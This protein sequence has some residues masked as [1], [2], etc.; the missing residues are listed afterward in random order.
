[1]EIISLAKRIGTYETSI[2]PY[3]DC[4]TIFVPDHPVINPD[5]E[6]CEEYEK[7]IPY[8]EM[9]KEAVLNEEIV[10]NQIKKEFEDY[11]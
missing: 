3:E 6:K 8:E 5:V 4:C 2:L 1:M 11:L 10:T 9:I 7:L